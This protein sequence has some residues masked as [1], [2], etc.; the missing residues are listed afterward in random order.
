MTTILVLGSPKVHM[1]RFYLSLALNQQT[2]PFRAPSQSNYWKCVENLAFFAIPIMALT[3]G[4]WVA[5][6]VGS[7]SS[8]VYKSKKRR[9]TH[10]ISSLESPTAALDA[11]PDVFADKGGKLSRQTLWV[12]QPRRYEWALFLCVSNYCS[13]LQVTDLVQDCAGKCN[14]LQPAPFPTLNPFSIP[15][16]SETI[17]LRVLLITPPPCMHLRLGNAGS[18]AVDIK[19]VN[20]SQSMT[21]ASNFYPWR[22]QSQKD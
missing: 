2:T 15:C 9:K 5:T 22:W 4:I 12:R 6:A 17:V 13:S 11:M 18:G 10:V 3:N 20:R 19:P 8:C 7:F 16:M 1:G 21:V 14:C